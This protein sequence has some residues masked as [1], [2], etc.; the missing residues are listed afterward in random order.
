M[1]VLIATEG[2][3]NT[4]FGHVTRCISLYQAFE[5]KG[6]AT[7]F[8]VNGDNTVYDLL[9]NTKHIV[10]NWLKE[11]E[12]FFNLLKEA[13]IAVIDSY[14][15]DYGIY[16]RISDLVKITV[17]IDDN[18]RIDYPDGIVVNGTIFA[19]KMNYP[20][21]EG[22]IYLL[23]S[24]YTPMRKEFWEVPQKRTRNGKE[25]VMITFG[26]DDSRN[27]T[28]KVLKLLVDNCPELTKN[29]IIG[30][31][32]QDTNVLEK[33]KD[34]NTKLIYYPNAE[35][36]KNIMLESDI[37]ISAGG[38]TLYELARTGV[39]AIAIAVADNQ[40]NNIKGWQKA[41][42]IEYAGWW[43]DGGI[44]DNILQ[45]MQLFR[46]P[47]SRDEKIKIGRKMADGRGAIRIAEYCIKRYY[48]QNLFLRKA[49][50]KDIYNIYELSNEPEIRNNSFSYEQVE[51]DSHKKWFFD[52]LNDKSCLFLIAEINNNFLG[53][54]RFDINDAESVI[55]VSIGSKH[56]GLGAGRILIDKAI[57]FLRLKNSDIRHIKA[58]IKKENSASV[59]LFE[60]ADFKFIKMLKVK[61]QDALEYQY[62]L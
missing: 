24:R 55:S 2:S 6:M 23:G 45:K 43:E 16:K 9:K 49:E 62:Q 20:E 33:I 54:V 17:Y 53:Q 37:A 52:K 4:G 41:G 42:F 15:T 32:F 40:L 30:K 28:A 35:G 18:R 57:D 26:G 14:L 31:G 34:K 10:F 61:N 3:S 47:G 60:K 29:V 25:N 22:I 12:R 48:V 19:E 21:R 51:L 59:R 50:E 5:E 27:M 7:E 46:N 58:F 56:R 36:M 13:D 44:L 1:R 8:I 11:L 39:P 38:Q